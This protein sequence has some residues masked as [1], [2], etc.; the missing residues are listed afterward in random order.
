MIIYTGN[1]KQELCKAMRSHSDKPSANKK[2]ASSLANSFISYF[3]RRKLVSSVGKT[4]DN[5]DDDD[6]VP[7][8]PP[9]LQLPGNSLHATAIHSSAASQPLTAN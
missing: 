1:D 9:P 6:E 2:S 3:R 8:L 7:L 4:S 5:N